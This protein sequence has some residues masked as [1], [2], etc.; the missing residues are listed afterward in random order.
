MQHRE[1]LGSLSHSRTLR[2]SQGT[3]EPAGPRAKKGHTLDATAKRQEEDVRRERG[4]GEEEGPGDP[5]KDC[6]VLSPRVEVDLDVHEPHLKNRLAAMA[7]WDT[8]PL[9]HLA[10]PLGH[11]AYLLLER[12]S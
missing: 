5:L 11:E 8:V 6:F 3:G 2:P 4:G 1:F 10:E 12:S 9:L 7:N